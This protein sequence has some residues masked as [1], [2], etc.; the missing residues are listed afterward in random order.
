MKRNLLSFFAMMLLL[1]SALMAQIPQ[2][3]YDSATGLSGDA[4]K[5]ALNNII[6]GHTEYPYSSTSTDVWDIL[7]G[8]DRDP[9]NPDNVLCIYSKFSVNAAAEY[10]NADGWNKEHV[11]AK[12]RGDFGTT[13]GPGTDLHHIRAADV[14]T[15][16]ARNN[17]N[18]DEAP[19]PY[20]DK[21]GTNN[22]ATPAYTSD[23]DWIWEPPADVKGDIARMLMY[24]T[25]R[26][27]GFDGEPDLELQEAYLDNVSKEPTQARLST[28]IQWHLNDPVDDEERRRNNVVYSYQH[29]RNPFIDHPEFVCEIFDCGGTQP[30]NSAPVFTS[31]VVVDATENVAY[32]YNITATDVD[33]DNLSFSASSLPSWLSLT[34]NGNGSAVLSGTPLA[35]HVGVNSVGLSVSDGQVSAVQNFQITVVGENVSAGAGDLFFSEY[36]EG[37]SNNKA[38]EVA[39]FT[40]STVDLSAYTIK[41]QTNG[42]G[43]WSGGLVLSGTLANQDVF[44]AA[45]SSAVAEITSQADYTGGVGEMTFNG[46]DALGLF[47]NGVLI[48]I[49]GNFDG[50]SAY[51]A[52]DQTMRRKSNIQSPNVTYSVSEWDVLAKDTFTG[53]GSHV[54]DGGGEVPDVEAPSTPENLTSSNITENGF[55]ISWSASTDNIA[56]TNYEVYLN[57]VL[58]ANQTSQAYSFSSL[59]AGTT[60]TVKVIA[61]D[62]AGNSSTSASINVQTIAPDTQAPTSPGNLVSSNITENSFDISWSASADNV[63]V[64]AYEVY[65]NDVLVNTQL[66][67]SYSFSSLNAGTTYA[68][69]VIAKDEAGNS[70]AAA[71]INVQTIAPDSQAPTVP[72]NLAVANVSQTGF[73]VSWSASTDNVAVTAYEVYL[74]NIL[75]ETQASTNYGF[76]SLSASTTY[77]VKVMAKDEAGNTSAATQLSVT[78]KSAPSS[79]VLIASD[80]E[81]GWDNWI[82]GGSDVSLYSGI[83]SYQGSYSVNL[84][85]NS[86]TASA[87]TS[88]TFDITAYNQIDIEFYYYSYSMETN[89]DFF[90]KYFD[91][92]S[93]QTVASF[94][95]GVDFDNNN[96]YVATLSFDASLYNFAANAKFRFQC[97]ASSNSDD[98]YIDLVTITASNNATKS[99]LVHNVSSVYVKSGLELD[100]NIENEVNIYPNPASEYFDLSLSLEQEVDLT[101]YIYDLNGRLVSS[102]K[103]LNCVGDYTKRMNVSGLE[104]GMYLVV[105]KGDDINFSKRL[106]VK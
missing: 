56:V 99:N 45:N 58:I 35:A 83:R 71:N 84:Q 81:S 60:Y 17:R 32:S 22:G 105:V 33:N 94:V 61:K 88:A 95:S 86:G 49:I 19:T 1:S 106:V 79:K 70:S 9:N 11:W 46:N 101:I 7:K 78:T 93:W 38:L 12:S 13:K 25:V 28:L 97:D 36:I 41:K 76:T 72:A 15:N 87:M 44:V 62:E 85:D 34:D 4:L 8:A 102:T 96:Y 48:D 26:Y 42:A 53:L 18:F 98:I 14:S 73:D 63:A 64:T 20:V 3:Y 37:S 51:F 23:V 52:Q 16:S 67:Q 30:T 103:E 10:N 21:G 59:N 65:L 54:F 39:N 66:S 82:D 80:F 68:V 89:E 2:G 74:D 29:N 104:S 77:I 50:G 55:D 43:L 69:K 57:N 5:S 24:M 31:S 75:V 40:G 90:V 92:S 27:E 91:G 100:E 6:K 47:K